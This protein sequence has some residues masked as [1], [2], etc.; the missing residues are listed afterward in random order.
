[1]SLS[2]FPVRLGRNGDLEGAAMRIVRR[3]RSAL[4]ALIDTLRLAVHFFA[5][6]RDISKQRR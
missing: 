2:P 3:L 4:S 6:A 5:L 1:M